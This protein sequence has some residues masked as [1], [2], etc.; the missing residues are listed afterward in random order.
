MKVP[1]LIKTSQ[2]VR[3][4][5]KLLE[6]LGD[7]QAALNIIGAPIKTDVH[8]TD[9]RYSQLACDIT[10]VPK[11]SDLFNVNLIF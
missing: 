4:K 8:P 5:I 11:G 2:E 10:T 1:P 7:I 6:A 9:Q 3:E